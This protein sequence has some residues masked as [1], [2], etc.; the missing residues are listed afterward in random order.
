MRRLVNTLRA[1]E[2]RHRRRDGASRR[3]PSSQNLG[4]STDQGAPAP[5]CK[6]LAGVQVPPSAARRRERTRPTVGKPW[7]FDG[8]RS[9]DM[10]LLFLCSQR[11]QQPEQF[12]PLR[13]VKPL[14]NRI[15]KRFGLLKRRLG[16]IHFLFN[17]NSRSLKMSNSR[18]CDG[19]FTTHI[20]GSR[21]VAIKLP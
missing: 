4:F 11:K 20:T 14:Q 6:H 21:R 19:G 17:H 13:F 2:C 3:A 15:Q 7:F 10:R 8:L 9:R 1:C 5:P 12:L 16:S 18:K